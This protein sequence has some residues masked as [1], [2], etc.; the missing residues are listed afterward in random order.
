MQASNVLEAAEPLAVEAA[1]QRLSRAV[2]GG[3]NWRNAQDGMDTWINRWHLSD[4]T[5][6]VTADVHPDNHGL[7]YSLFTYTAGVS[8]ERQSVFSSPDFEQIVRHLQN[9][10]S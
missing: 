7:R 2:S 1:A 8:R 4:G 6:H 5:L 9:P 10:G 3:Q